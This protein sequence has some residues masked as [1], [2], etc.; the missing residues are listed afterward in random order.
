MAEGDVISMPTPVPKNGVSELYNL[1]SLSQR[2]QRPVPG[3]APGGPPV[4]FYA[5]PMLGAVR[6]LMARTATEETNFI[7]YKSPDP[8]E[9]DA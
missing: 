7:M 2:S 1:A 4:G 6:L 8:P 5:P 3:T 9:N